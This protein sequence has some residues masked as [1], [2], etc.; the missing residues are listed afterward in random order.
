MG[1]AAAP[2]VIRLLPIPLFCDSL[3]SLM[4]LMSKLLSTPSKALLLPLPL[5]KS[6]HKI[7]V[8]ILAHDKYCE[9][10]TPYSCADAYTVHNY[11]DLLHFL[12]N[13]KKNLSYLNALL[14]NYL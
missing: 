8:N 12:I 7:L 13:I 9:Y 6:N 10:T 3:N 5:Q 2:I 1:A 14:L 11:C 4:S